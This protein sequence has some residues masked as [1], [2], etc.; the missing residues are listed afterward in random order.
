MAPPESSQVFNGTIWT[1]IVGDAASIAPIEIGSYYQSGVVFY[2]FQ[3]GEPGYVENETHGLM[4]DTNDQ[5]GG[6]GIAWYN[7][8]YTAT[9]AEEPGIGKG[10]INTALIISS[11]G[12]GT[13]AATV[14]TAYD[15]GNWF[16]PSQDELNIMG[17]S[18]VIINA[19][20][21]ANGGSAFVPGGW[22]WSST[23]ISIEWAVAQEVYEEAQSEEDKS[24]LYRVRAAKIF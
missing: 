22:Y 21:E 6:S 17:N 7:G 24:I 13:Y 11:Q 5:D 1:N 12:A 4:C 3:L 16:L 15:D 10:P 19:A 8:A 14:C 2:I 20:S 18:R 23:S 9:G